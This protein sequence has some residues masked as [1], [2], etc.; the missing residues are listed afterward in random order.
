MPMMWYSSMPRIAVSEWDHLNA[1]ERNCAFWAETHRLI[2]RAPIVG[3]RYLRVYV[4]RL[5]DE[6]VVDRLFEFL[7]LEAPPRDEVTALLSRHVHARMLDKTHI[8]KF[9]SDLLGEYRAWST[10]QQGALVR[11]CGEA[12]RAV[13]RP[14]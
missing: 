10:Q 8:A 7:G 9:R 13:D 14:L 4:D 6:G 1:F 12:S 5:S 2:L 11:L 3:D